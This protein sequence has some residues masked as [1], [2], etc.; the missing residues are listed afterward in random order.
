M[1]WILFVVLAL[2]LP[3]PFVGL[4]GSFVPVARYVQLGGALLVLIAIEGSGGMVGAIAGLL[5]GHAIVYGLLLIVVSKLIAGQI[6]A[7]LPMS[8]R[9]WI[10]AAI[11]VGLFVVAQFGGIYDSQFHHSRA[12]ASLGALYR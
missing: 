3:L 10:V 6:L 2:A 8:I 7:R 12:H 1:G 11:I 5:W 9:P 4:E